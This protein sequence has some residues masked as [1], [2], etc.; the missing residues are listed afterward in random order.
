MA[1]PNFYKILTT[2]AP[3]L[4]IYDFLQPWAP[5]LAETLNIPSVNFL[6]CSTT[7]ISFSIHDSG[8][9][10]V[11]YPFP[12]I[13]LHEH[14]VNQFNHRLD[15]FANGVKNADRIKDCY[16]RSLNI[17]LIKTFRELEGKHIDYLS[18]LTDKKMV[19]VGALVQEEINEEEGEEIIEWLNKKERLSTVFVS[20]GSEYF[21]SKKE[22]KEMA[23]GLELSKANF[24]WVVRF[25]MGE[26]V[27]VEEALPKGLLVDLCHCGWSSVM[28]SMKYGVPILAMPMH[29][30][31]PL[32][33]RVVEE[34]GVGVE[35]KKDQNGWI[36][37]EEVAKVV[38]EV[39]KEKNGES[40]RKKAKEMSEN[41]RNKGD[42]E[43][44]GVVEE[45]VQLC[46]KCN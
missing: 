11:K 45:L 3:N 41:L 13:Y 29:L 34:V 37:K 6:S 19:P 21:L 15:S 46:L 30:D 24:I 10:R 17:I 25:P 27:S 18:H 31:Q 39:I 20:F 8:N 26:K 14:E 43:I 9:P 35:I 28:E 44:D 33:A 5:A 32:N 36:Q 16:K 12:E 2:L 40:V 22:I 42:E 23:Q 7:M 1:S 4:L 38:K